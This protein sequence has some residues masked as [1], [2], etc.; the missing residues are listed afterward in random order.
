[1]NEPDSSWPLCRIVEAV[2]EQRLA[3]ALRD[4]AVRL[5]VDDQRI[6]RAPDIV[7]GACSARS[8]RVPSSG[9]ISTS[10]TWQP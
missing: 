1:M 4:A 6:D 7:D 2:L 8:R 3:D 10:H 9:S 5:A